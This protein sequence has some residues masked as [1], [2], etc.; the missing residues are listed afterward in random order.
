MNEPAATAI[1]LDLTQ[2]RPVR[3]CINHTGTVTTEWPGRLPPTVILPVLRREALV[4]GEAAETHR[5]AIGLQWPPEAR[6][7][8]SKHGSARIPVISAMA[9]LAGPPG[10]K[11]QSQWGRSRDD[12]F[13]W[14]VRS[15]AGEHGRTDVEIRRPPSEVITQ[16][17]LHWLSG[18]ESQSTALVIPDRFD[19]SAQ[20]SLLEH[21][22][23]FLV[24]RPIAVALHWCRTDPEAL[25][26]ADST[27]GHNKQVGCILVVTTALDSWEAVFVELRTWCAPSGRRHLIP[28]RRRPAQ[29]CELPW[30]GFAFHHA[31]A[32]ERS[33]PEDA[34]RALFDPQWEAPSSRAPSLAP[35]PHRNPLGEC[36]LEGWSR[37]GRRK[38][39]AVEVWS[40]LLEAASGAGSHEHLTRVVSQTAQN[41]AD[42][43]SSGACLACVID[44]S[45]T[46]LR[47]S[48]HGTLGNFLGRDL[49][50]PRV[51]TGDASWA[52]QGAAYAADAIASGLPPYLDA[53]V[54]VE[55]Y[56]LAEDGNRD[57]VDRWKPLIDTDIVPAGKEYSSAH[58]ITGLSISAGERRLAVT[59]QRAA[60]R[61]VPHYKRVMLDITRP[62]PDDEPVEL[63]VRLHT[64]QGYPRVSVVSTTSGVLEGTL[65]WR[66][67]KDCS[68]PTRPLLGYISGVALVQHRPEIW[69]AARDVLELA[70]KQLPRTSDGNARFLIDEVR[71]LANKAPQADRWLRRN[72]MALTNNPLLHFGMFPSDG[73]WSVFSDQRLQEAKLLRES[74]LRIALSTKHSQ[75]TVDAAHR[76]LSWMYLACPAAIVE[77]SRKRLGSPTHLDLRTMGMCFSAGS[78]LGALV[79]RIAGHLQYNRTGVNNWLG[80]L[81]NVVR[82]R[83]HSLSHESLSRIDIDHLFESVLDIMREQ[84]EGSNYAHIFTNCVWAILGLLKRR[85]YEPDFVG[86]TTKL[87]RRA[88]H[89]I[90]GCLPPNGRRG[91]PCISSVQEE[92][93]VR[94][95][96]FLRIEATG[97]DVAGVLRLIDDEDDGS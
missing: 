21:I 16:T 35:S 62:S 78:D 55:L 72:K 52:A 29:G 84:H 71:S 40:D 69:D 2:H 15:D 73:D 5:R 30:V 89:L 51:L 49:G 53:I 19:E 56:C 82:F 93:L 23:T 54:P 81:K 38:V 32:V 90:T 95:R 58:P 34:W 1:G 14:I 37:L 25:R 57:L 91:S 96:T 9:R 87:F 45:C 68:A 43:R 48:S 28:V 26:L 33:G 85:R 92:L 86:R 50:V 42:P 79:H 67:M 75:K 39:E 88:D 65:D 63:R 97:E 6:A 10:I 66:T 76:L 80:A 4:V 20:Q 61:D 12:D 7:P 18:P 47:I 74:V 59:L 17:A 31:L 46:E 24:P 77:R 94:T 44:G 41:S 64:G 11:G 3:S 8:D 36:L 22:R 13:R 60:I 83:Q 27:L 70:I